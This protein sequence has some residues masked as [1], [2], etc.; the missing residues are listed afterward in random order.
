MIG[1]RVE[2]PASL[3]DL[4]T[5]AVGQAGDSDE[6]RGQLRALFAHRYASIL[7]V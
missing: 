6:L 4:A 3:I 7:A 1:G 2:E 5:A